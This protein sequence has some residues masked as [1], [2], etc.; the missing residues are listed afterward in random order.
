MDTLGAI[1]TH[2][3]KIDKAKMVE[4]YQSSLRM[5]HYADAGNFV[6]YLSDKERRSAQIDLYKSL[7]KKNTDADDTIAAR[8]RTNLKFTGDELQNIFN[9]VH[10]YV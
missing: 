5:G 1:M 6:K 4:A 2:T 10:R 7:V 9:E 3:Q 8:L